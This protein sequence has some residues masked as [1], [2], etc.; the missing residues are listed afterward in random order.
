[1]YFGVVLVGHNTN[2]CIPAS[3][4]YLID[5]VRAY[6]GRGLNQNE[7]KRIFFSNNLKKTP[8]FLLPLRDIFEPSEN[9]CYLAKIKRTFY[10]MDEAKK[11]MKKQRGGL[12]TVYNNIIPKTSP[13]FINGEAQIAEENDRLLNVKIEINEQIVQLRDSVIRVNEFVPVIDL[14]ICASDDEI[15]VNEAA[16]EAANEATNDEIHINEAANAIDDAFLWESN[17]TVNSFRNLAFHN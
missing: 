7:K 9:A 13:E 14:T 12:P 10:T 6:N 15:Q 16:N 11:F 5:P 4:V 1:M 3:W 17:G 8:N 2:L